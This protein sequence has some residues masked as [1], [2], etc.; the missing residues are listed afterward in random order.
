MHIFSKIKRARGFVVGL[1][2]GLL[3]A[4]MATSGLATTVKQATVNFYDDIKIYVNGGEITPTAQNG[5]TI[6]PILHDGTTYLPVRAVSE[7]LGK[8]VEWDNATRSVLIGGPPHAITYTPTKPDLR[9]ASQMSIVPPSMAMPFPIDTDM[10]T[11]ATSIWLSDRSGYGTQVYPDVVYDTRDGEELVVQIITPVDPM[12]M[13]GGS[14]KEWPLIVYVPGSA[15][16]RQNVYAAYANM[17]RVAEM[18]YAVAI[19]EYRGTDISMFPSA[20]EDTKTAIRFMKT[21]AK[22]YGI[23]ADKVAVWGDSSG[24]H[25]ADM[26]GI[27]GDDEFNTGVYS[28]VSASVNVVVDWYGPTDISV[29]CYYPSM[30]DHVTANSPEGLLL[31]GV[32]VLENLD[33]AKKASPLTYLD[34][35]TAIP[36]ILIMHGSQDSIVPFNQSVRLHEKL[37]ELGKDST[38]YKVEGGSHGSGGFASDD[39]LKLV[40]DYITENLK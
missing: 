40:V 27:T 1:V 23:D 22:T 36:P 14:S 25:T 17:I 33:L 26:V 5:D 38:F 21:N 16:M 30:L 37:V 34:A 10:P 6:Y 11:G 3:V 19:V 35:K 13:F 7:A 20:I 29:M 15:W 24:G 39:A 4:A 8:S 28:D 12:T 31:G 2:V 32:N 9:P 18:G